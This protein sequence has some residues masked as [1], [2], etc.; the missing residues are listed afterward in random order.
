MEF[1]D[2]YNY[3]DEELNED[4]DFKKKLQKEF[5]TSYLTFYEKVVKKVGLDTLTFSVLFSLLLFLLH[6]LSSQIEEEVSSGYNIVDKSYFL[7]IING[8]GLY[9]ILSATKK[10][11]E[12]IINLVQLSTRDNK[13]KSASLL[14]FYSDFFL[15]RT[16]VYWGLLFGIINTVVALIFGVKYLHAEEPQYYLFSSFMLQVFTV[17]FIGGITIRGTVL[18]VKLINRFSEKEELNLMYF[19]PDKCG[20][21]LIV[22]NVLFL[23]AMCFVGIGI[24]IFLFIDIYEWSYLS[25]KNPNQYIAGLSFFWKMLPMLLAGIIFFLP[26]K[27]LSSVLKEYKNLEQMKIRKRMNH[28]NKMIVKLEIDKENEKGAIENLDHH[29]DKLL[30]IDQ[31]IDELNTLPYNLQYRATFLSVFLPVATTMLDVPKQLI[32]KIMGVI[33]G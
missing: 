3:Y 32:D 13:E 9:L 10:M 18:V 12:F 22:G 33:G 8:V 31:Q 7:S 19:H 29:Y 25:V 26:I 1:S 27:K 6:L 14:S 11:R 30:K 15:G 2:A 24:L 16:T 28:L 20:G 17:G 21:T 4:F 23:F 5:E